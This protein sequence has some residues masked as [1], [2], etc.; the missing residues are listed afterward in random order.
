MSDKLDVL[1]KGAEVVDGTGNPS[2]RSDV[3]VID[4]VISRVERKIDPA[5]ANTIISADGMVVSPGFI[6]V[7]THDDFLVL[8]RPAAEEKILQ[9][10]T[11]VVTGNCGESPAPLVKDKE[12][13][14]RNHLAGIGGRAAP[15]HLLEMGGFKDYLE[16]VEAAGPSV[17][18]IPLVGCAAIRF[19]LLGMENRA[20]NPDELGAM[21]RLTAEAMEAGAFGLSTG[22]IYSPGAFAETV[23]IIELVRVAARF[24]GLYTSHIRNESDALLPALAEAIVIGEEAGAPVH[25]SH[26]K[27]GG[28][29]N[30]GRSVESLKMMA[31][32][33]AGGLRITCDQYPYRAGS[34]S[35]SALLP[36]GRLAMHPDELL[37]SLADPGV[38]KEIVKE[39]E[40]GEGAAWE[41]LIMSAGFENI[42]LSFCPNH[43]GRS[44][45]SISDIAGSRGAS[46]YDVVFDI[47][48]E[49]KLA[50][51]M[52]LFLM[53]DEDVER[54]FKS[55]FTMVGSDG[56]P[57][58]GASKVHPRMTG[59]FP[60]V[61][62]RFVRE[63]KLVSLEEAVRKCTS[64]SAET[65][66]VKNK[67]L[68]LEGYDA[69]LVVFDPGAVLDRS[70]YEDPDSP[71][72]GIG[73]V[74]VNGKIAAENGVA[75]GA[76]SGR[77]LRRGGSGGWGA[78]TK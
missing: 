10:V 68:L 18:V 8:L 38:R 35:L 73:H 61:L 24:G 48:I 78:R 75:A 72:A 39:I 58:F 20:P 46:E 3:G 12:S 15:D 17:N 6:D 36:P 66:G 26:H 51:T 22:L 14:I 64:L 42:V 16:K 2:Y 43:P 33:R 32:A 28:E 56:M 47:L 49:E 23:E 54:I 19:A 65:F 50:A 37:R 1:I 27:V 4:G 70:T 74:L 9:G 59:T 67:G 62:G 53:C 71:P 45:R 7:H 5:G 77:V 11:S 63:K 60:R 69:D 30:W 25:V 21:K 76:G 55:P 41:N 57:G 34:T 40:R 29:K 31:E 52:I 13:F 44:G